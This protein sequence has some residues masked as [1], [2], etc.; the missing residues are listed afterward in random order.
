MIALQEKPAKGSSSDAA[1]TPNP[2]HLHVRPKRGLV[3][4]EKPTLQHINDGSHLSLYL[5]DETVQVPIAR[6]F[7]LL[8]SL[9]LLSLFL[10]FCLGSARLLV[11]LP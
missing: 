6:L 10:A 2:W 3:S 7:S 9:L 1:L 5:L 11:Y 8:D 4:G